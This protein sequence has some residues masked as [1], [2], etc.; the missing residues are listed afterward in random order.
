[1]PRYIY[2]D[3]SFDPKDYSIIHIGK[4]C[5]ISREVMLLTHDC[6]MHTVYNEGKGFSLRNNEKI[7]A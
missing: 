5:T 6:S 4:V 3:T 2:N 1:M 7:S